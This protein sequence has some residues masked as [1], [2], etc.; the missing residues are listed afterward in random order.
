MRVSKLSK[1]YHLFQQITVRIILKILIITTFLQIVK[2]TYPAYEVI[3][4]S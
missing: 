4:I 2:T 3:R 1:S